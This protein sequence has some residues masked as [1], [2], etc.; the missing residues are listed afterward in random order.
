M[1]AILLTGLLL[2][3]GLAQ[4][5]P[6]APAEET[7]KNVTIQVPC[8]APAAAPAAP[9][10]TARFTADDL[11]PLLTDRKELL[12]IPLQFEGNRTACLDAVKRVNMGAVVDALLP[13]LAGEFADRFVPDRDLL[14]APVPAANQVRIEDPLLPGGAYTGPAEEVVGF[15]LH[16]VSQDDYVRVAIRVMQTAR[17]LLESGDPGIDRTAPGYYQEIAA[18]QVAALKEGQAMRE[19]VR[20]QFGEA[21]GV[22]NEQGE[23]DE[24]QAKWVK[25]SRRFSYVVRDGQFIGR[26]KPLVDEINQAADLAGFTAPEFPVDK[27]GIH[28][29]GDLGD[30]EILLPRD[31]VKAFLDQADVLE[32]RMAEES[33]I[34]VEVVRLTDRDIQN[35]AVASRLNASFQGVHDTQYGFS[36]KSV[37]RQ[38]GIN[39]L[40]AIANRELSITNANAITAGLIPEGTPAVQLPPYVLPSLVQPRATPTIGTSFAIGADDVFF[41]GREQSFGFSYIGPDGI[42]HVLSYDVVDSLRQFWERIERN[43]IVH[44]ILKTPNKEKFTVPVGPE[45]KTFEGIAALISQQNQNLVVATGTG[46]LSELSATAGTWL[47][48]KDFEITP[49][50]GSSTALSDEERQMIRDRVMMTMLLRDPMIPVITKTRL[51]ELEDRTARSDRLTDLLEELDGRPLRPGRDER[52]F[53]SLFRSRYDDTREV[54]TVEKKERN[55][56]ISMTFYS[57]QGTIQSNLGITAL[58][59]QNDLT[60]FTTQLS[61]NRVTPIS[62]FF[63][64]SASNTQDTSSLTGLARGENEIEEKARTHLVIRARFPDDERERQD[65]EEGRFLG[66]FQLP[67]G[68]DPLSSVNLPFLSSSEHP[69]ERL[70]Q[71]RPGL[72]FPALDRTRIRQPALLLNPNRIVGDVPRDVWEAC[73]TRYLFNMRIIADTPTNDLATVAAYRQRF[74]VEVRSLLE[75]DEDLFDAP[76]IALRN[77]DHW[78]DPYRIVTALNNSAERFAYNRLIKLI[79][80][81]G[82]ALLD[83]DFIEDRLAVAE[84]DF[85]GNRRLRPLTPDEVRDLRRDVAAHYLRVEEVYG[86][87]FL[88]AVAIVLGLNTYQT[89]SHK[90]A[91]AGPFV[92]YERLAMFDRTGQPFIPPV[93]VEQAHQDFVRLREGGYKGRLFQPSL[94]FVEHMPKDLRSFVVVGKDIIEHR[95]AFTVKAPDTY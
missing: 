55:S 32:R 28:F 85:W 15:L 64:R 27:P 58:G 79:D 86:D 37:I 51:V 72:L 93:Q 61:P 26:L 80:D 73:T 60:S 35:G 2:L 54:A 84:P 3:S 10:F 41:D 75:Y 45:T 74:V 71:N 38:V 53:G 47:V 39:A 57:S 31:Y 13:V 94:E 49:I 12:P 62:S 63:T 23:L 95:Q 68:K 78:N 87:A 25:E 24:T 91:T 43:L 36:E 66:Y 42:E 6:A 76:N 70:A 17:Q 40:T 92:G 67:M 14:V 46:A 65:R 7:S 83:E 16:G 9:T 50:P 4:A 81:M 33:M 44:K 22:Y 20:R 21:L 90:E 8:P 69:L 5:E 82:A 59:D 52:S 34:S 48:I 11:E 89:L 29:D 88:E 56:K 30:V 1:N 18:R 77:M 19:A